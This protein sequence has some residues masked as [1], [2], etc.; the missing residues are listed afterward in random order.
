MKAI[1]TLEATAEEEIDDEELDDTDPIDPVDDL[2]VSTAGLTESSDL[3]P[4]ELSMPEQ[5]QSLPAVPS[6]SPTV[7]P[8][9]NMPTSED[10]AAM[11]RDTITAPVS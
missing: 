10:Y 8:I 1:E 5:P 11:M 7:R 6:T 4:A 9:L 2:T 3:V